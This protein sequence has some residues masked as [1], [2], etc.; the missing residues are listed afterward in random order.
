MMRFLRGGVRLT[1]KPPAATPMAAAIAG[2]ESGRE[3]F[4][5]L[6]SKQELTRAAFARVGPQLKSRFTR[7]IAWLDRQ[8]YTL[9]SCEEAPLN[10]GAKRAYLRYDV[11]VRDLFG[12]V[13]LASLHEELKV[14]G[15]FQVCWEHSRAERAVADIFLKLQLFDDRY[16][17]FG[18][19]CS[20]ES[21]WII[22]ERFNGNGDALERF[23]GDGGA[24]AMIGGWSVAFERDGHDAPLLIEARCKAE[25]RFGAIAAS[26]RHHFGPAKTLSGHGTSLS[27]YYLDAVAKDARYAP[28]APYLHPVDF[29][30]IDRIRRHGFA[31]ELTRFADVAVPGPQI[32]FENPVAQMASL[33]RERMSQRRGFVVLFHPTSWTSGHFD[34][35]LAA[36]A[37]PP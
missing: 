14:P 28:L 30:D 6:S 19:H 33:Y 27:G 15:S 22:A 35:F 17:E 37:G 31:Q 26:F 20:P 8:G 21:S 16:V 3:A 36:V 12:A 1:T 2:V 10:L 5:T 4:G 34:P 7:Y 25:E 24:G 18:L 23:V 13:A 9:G 32:I 11:H 29:L